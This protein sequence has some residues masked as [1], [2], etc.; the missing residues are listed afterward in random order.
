MISSTE[1]LH[2]KILIVDDQ[3]ANILLLDRMLRG[4]GYVS[5]SSTNDPNEVC[6]LHSRNR[7]DLILLDLE[8]PNL[9]FSGFQVMDRLKEIET[10]GILPVI[11]ITAHPDHRLHALQAGARDFISKPFE[12]EEALARIRNM[13]EIRLLHVAMKSQIKA[14]EQ[15]IKAGN[16][17]SGKLAK[18]H[19]APGR[20]HHTVLYVED[21]PENMELVKKIIARHSDIRLLAA[22]SGIDWIDIACASRP[23]VILMDINLPGVNGIDALN[24]L[25]KDPITAHIPV[26]AV[27]A[28]AMSLDLKNIKNRG[29]FS[30]LNKP[31]E[32]DELMEALNAALEFSESQR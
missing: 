3:D 15:K 23:D 21:D 26:I 27:S 6:D 12:L 31:I 11:V 5:I 13:L 8:M 10:G 22:T 28:N 24:I 1:I 7:Y 14:L 25:G 2:A 4:A 9:A 30:Y 16:S 29:F 19:P 17:D 18:S 20:K 32:V